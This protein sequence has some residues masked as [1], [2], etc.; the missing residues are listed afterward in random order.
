[1]AVGEI[2]AASKV[3][4][5]LYKFTQEGQA[6]VIRAISPLVK[7]V[8]AALVMNHLGDGGRHA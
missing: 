2:G 5:S 7:Y 3:W 1:M 6:E 8:V 4:V